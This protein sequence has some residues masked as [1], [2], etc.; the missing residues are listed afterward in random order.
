MSQIFWERRCGETFYGG[1]G[2]IMSPGYPNKYDPNLKC[3][4]R[5]EASPNDYVQIEF[6]EPFQLEPGMLV[7]NFKIS[8]FPLWN[9]F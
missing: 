5:L 1:N 2:L 8:D 4:Y 3:E 6:L 7:W 9:N